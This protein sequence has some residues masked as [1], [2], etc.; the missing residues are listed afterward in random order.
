MLLG[1]SQEQ[2]A[3]VDEIRKVGG[4]LKVGAGLSRGSERG[5]CKIR[6]F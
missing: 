2:V 5:F 6:A 3:S 4:D 1:K